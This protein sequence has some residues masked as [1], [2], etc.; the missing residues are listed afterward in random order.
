[1]N[2]IAENALFGGGSADP[3]VVAWCYVEYCN[4]HADLQA[5]LCGAV[6][7][8]GGGRGAG[9]GCAAGGQVAAATDGHA[10]I[11]DALQ[12]VCKRL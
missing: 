7:A 10:A 2:F 1:M 12:K 9:M 8:C 11:R 6:A 4:A 3:T 5:S